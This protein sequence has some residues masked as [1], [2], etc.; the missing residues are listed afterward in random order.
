M[1]L[2]PYVLCGFK[3]LFFIGK[4][5]AL[6]SLLRPLGRRELKARALGPGLLRGRLPF[7]DLVLVQKRPW[8]W[9]SN[10]KPRD[11]GSFKALLRW[12]GNSY[13]TQIALPPPLGY[14]KSCPAMKILLS[15]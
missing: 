11:P 14:N 1:V 15:I 8:P 2:K 9:V 5:K 3:P 13:C 7:P 10:W 4:L 6:Q 12:L